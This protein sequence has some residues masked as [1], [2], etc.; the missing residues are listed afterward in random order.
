MKHTR[1]DINSIFPQKEDL[2]GDYL[3]G[4][5]SRTLGVIILVPLL[6]LL[7]YNGAGHTSPEIFT[8]KNIISTLL[9]ALG[10]WLFFVSWKY[11]IFLG[12]F[13]VFAPTLFLH[14]ILLIY[15]R[16]IRRVVN[17]VKVDD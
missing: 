9:V 4:L 1:Y 11:N 17:Y 3:F 12:A 16:S 8:F 13:L 10:L 5:F 14:L 2:L 15:W 7:N 6:G